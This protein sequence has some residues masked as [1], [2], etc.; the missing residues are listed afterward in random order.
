MFKRK[1]VVLRSKKY[2]KVIKIAI[3]VVAVIAS[4]CLIA[5][6]WQKY[7]EKKYPNGAEK[8][9][10]LPNAFIDFFQMAS[11]FV[12]RKNVNNDMSEDSSEQSSLLSEE[13]REDT[14]MIVGGNSSES[15]SSAEETQQ[16]EPEIKGGIV[17]E[18]EAASEYAFRN[19][20]FVGDY[21]VFGVSASKYFAYSSFAYAT[22]Y[23]MNTIQTKD[24]FK[25]D[26][27]ALT[28]A[29]YVAKFDNIDTVYIAFSAESVSWM[30]CPTFV[31]KYTDFIDSIIA[32]QPD[33]DIYIQPLLPIDEK[34]AK[35]RGY[36]VTN[37]K[38]DE[39][40]SYLL[41]IAEKKDIWYLD[42]TESFKSGEG[43][44]EEEATGNGIRL[45]EA[46]YEIWYNYIITHKV[47]R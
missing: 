43:A 15:S 25:S 30:D 31:K 44:S 34:Q 12:N 23:D 20:L 16:E 10:K 24:A 19:T 7:D 32:A 8:D 14:H 4:S 38:I 18:G 6:G 33:A 35:K 28:M 47:F 46:Q 39:I 42:M 5:Y 1:T 45:N 13:S 36:S 17:P 9:Y 27:E 29:E 40:N 3:I 37:E 22:G 2:G 11:D 41:S 26:G 21:F